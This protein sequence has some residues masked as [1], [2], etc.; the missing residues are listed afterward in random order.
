MLDYLIHVAGNLGHWAYLVI[1]IVVVLECQVLLGLVMPG[2]SLVLLGGFFAEQGLLD[3]GDLIFVI[4]VAA[5]LGDS[6]G[7]ELGRYLGPGWLLKHGARLGLRQEHLDRVEGAF[8]HHGGKAVFGSH[9]LHLL[10]ALMPFVAGVHRMRYLKFLLFNAAGC[11]VWASVFVSIGYLAGASWQVAAKW[12]GRTSEIVGAALLLVIVLGWLWRWLGRHETEVKQRWQAVAEH[13]RMLALRRRFAPQLEFLIN[14]LSPRGY[15]GLHLTLGVLFILGASWLFGG[16]AQDV[17]AG[18]PLT[19]IDR[20]VAVWFH[21][22]RTPGLTTAMELITSLASTPWVT[23]VGV[24]CALVL[25]RKHCWYRLLTLVLVLPGG[26]ALN[27]LLKIAFHRQRPS[28]T[29]SFLIFNGYSFPSGH[30]MAATLLYGLL[31]AFAVIALKAWRWRVATVLGAFVMV[32]LVGF[33]RI[34]LGAHYLSDVL[35]AAAAGSTWLAL[36]FTAV[37]SL[38]RRRA[39]GGNSSA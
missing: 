30:T 26:M 28:F 3:P 32:L 15:L 8:V 14:R 17:L 34:Y 25:W 27:L 12:I 13:P 38:R 21:E 10:R 20:N 29:D 23:S 16:I 19:V 36:V 37:G 22:R 11:I 31:A 6:I 24:V 2:E 5:I 1:F 7:Y 35:G 33:S 18:D 39:S 9:F 4:S